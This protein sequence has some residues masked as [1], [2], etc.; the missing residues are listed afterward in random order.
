MTAEKDAAAPLTTG[1]LTE[2]ELTE[3][4]RI[5]EADRRA[6]WLWASVRGTLAWIAAL[7]AGLVAFRNDIG[8]VI[9]MI[10]ASKP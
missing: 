5:L 7:V 6:K 4:R 9:K 1:P 3:L 10:I 8:E 2:A